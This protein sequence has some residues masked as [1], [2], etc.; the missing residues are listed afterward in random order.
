MRR[1]LAWGRVEVLTRTSSSSRHA[2]TSSCG[3][4]KVKRAL[5]PYI[6]NIARH[7][8]L[9]AHLAQRWVAYTRLRTDAGGGEDDIVTAGNSPVLPGRVQ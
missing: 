8:P 5:S 4:W 2:L 9:R 3:H 7:L 6:E 1:F